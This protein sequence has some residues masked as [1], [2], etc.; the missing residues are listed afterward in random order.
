MFKNFIGNSFCSAQPFA[1]CNITFLE[2]RGLSATPEGVYD[3]NRPGVARYQEFD[4]GEGT[5]SQAGVMSMSPRQTDASAN[6]YLKRPGLKI[7]KNY[8]LSILEAAAE[9][10]AG[11]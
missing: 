8:S 1:C 3:I 10:N 11:R 7:R 5:I 6:E 9:K 4:K 2:A